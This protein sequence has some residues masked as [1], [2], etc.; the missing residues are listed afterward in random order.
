MNRQRIILFVLFALGLFFFLHN[1]TLRLADDDVGWLRGEAPTVFDQY[2]QIPRLFFVSLQTLFGPSAPAALAMIWLFHCLNALLLYRLAQ[3]L[4]ADSPAAL[5]AAAVFLIN[6]LTLKTLTWISCF[7]YVLGATLALLSLLAFCH[8]SSPSATLRTS[9][10]SPISSLQMLLPLL[11][12]TAGL[13]CTHE[14]LFLPVLFFVLSWL[15]G[16]PKQ[17]LVLLVAGMAIALLVNTF[18]Y[19]F[20]R[21]GVEASRLFS[22]DFALAYASSGLSS[23]LA[24]DLAYPL[25]FFAQTM[26]F[27][28]F[29]FSEPV[30]WSMTTALLAAGVLFSTNSKAWRLA[31]ALTL[32]FLA[33]ITPYIIRL[34]LTPDTVNF[35]ISYVLSGRVFYLPFA[36]IALVLGWATSGLSRTLPGSFASY[37]LP[38]AS[39]LAYGHA[40]WLYD[41]ADFLGLNV[42][43][44]LPQPMPPRWNPYTSQ[45]PAWLALAGLV[46]VLCVALRLLVA[47]RR[48]RQLCPT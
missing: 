21:Y 28:R 41:K 20:G 39:L 19:D 16:Q 26:D 34:Y 24:L 3:R 6:P 42:A 47:R 2:R 38:L 44:A 35:D 40:L 15:Q 32:S 29:C 36:A 13:F 7:S 22:F 1:V 25:S 31:L 46:L 5:I 10:Q 14:I 23:G 37:L 11:C 33:L 17:G 12:F 43:T 27:L 18:V 9:L 48:R 8:T 4:L 30:R 45:H